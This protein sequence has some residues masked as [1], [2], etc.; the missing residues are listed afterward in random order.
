MIEIDLRTATK[1]QKFF[2]YLKNNGFAYTIL[3]AVG[4][5][6]PILWNLLGPSLTKKATE[7]YLKRFHPP[8]LNLGSGS[9]RIK[10]MLN[11]DIDARADAYVNITKPLPFPDAT[12]QYIYSEEVIEHV[13][14][15]HAKH[16]LLECYRILM[17]GGRIRLTT[18]SLDFFCSAFSDSQITEGAV[19]DIFYHHG[20]LHIYSENSL[21]E[22]L[23]AA[24]F[25]SI[26]F[27]DYRSIN[28]P[29]GCYDSHADRFSENPKISLYADALKP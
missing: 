12:F 10:G 19:N 20:H 3:S 28:S 5:P 25:T 1:K 18:P 17:P 9:N 27:S 24:G 23:V 15:E 4:R 26:S 2:F 14:R 13:S 16:L 7:R 21:S 8:S 6:L 22:I 11:V 29:L